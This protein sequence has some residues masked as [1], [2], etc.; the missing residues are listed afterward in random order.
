MVIFWRV[1]ATRFKEPDEFGKIIIGC[2]FGAAGVAALWLGTILTPAGGK[3]S[4][5]WLLLFHLFNDIG[6]ANVLP[7]GLALFARAAPR[8][9]AGAVIG[10][11]YLHLFAGN[12]LAG[13]IGA[14]LEN[15]P[16]A[17]FWLLHVALVTGAGVVFA[18]ITPV[19][20]RVLSAERR[21]ELAPA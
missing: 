8:A 15:M 2:A 3:V 7:V 11:Y 16:A 4:F 19:F 20:R 9:I 10:I 13:Y 17:Q 1:W 21:P 5:G 14:Q 18:I 12:K 6:F